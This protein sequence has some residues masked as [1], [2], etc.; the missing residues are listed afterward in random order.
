MDH[1]SLSFEYEVLEREERGRLKIVLKICLDNVLPEIVEILAVF[2]NSVLD[3]R[4]KINFQA[5]WR[6]FHRKS[7]L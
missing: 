2:Q 3:L 5:Q 1:R 4:N 7:L 6:L